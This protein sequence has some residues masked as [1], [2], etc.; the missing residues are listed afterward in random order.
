MY[1]TRIMPAAL[2]IEQ[3]AGFPRALDALA[4]ESLAAHRFLRS[5][6]FAA[7]APNGGA[8]L[9]LR[10][11]DASLLAAIPTTPFGPALIGA[12]KVPG[13]YWPHRGVLAARDATADD[14]AHVLS[15]PQ[16]RNLG[17][18]W[19]LGPVPE[20][21]PAAR[22]LI[23]GAR[24][25]GW[26]VL[27]HHAGTIWTI[28]L[29]A[30]RARGWPSKSTRRKL[31]RYEALANELGK[32]EWRYVRG[33]DWDESALEQMG[34]IEAASWVGTSTDGSGA[35]FMAPHQRALWRAALADPVLAEMLCATILLINGRAVAFTFDMDDG[36]VQYGIAGSYIS[37]LRDYHVGKLT[38]YRAISDAIADGQAVM[39]MGA[40][41]SG[42][43]TE[44]G[45]VPAYDLVDHLFVRSRLVAGMLGPWWARQGV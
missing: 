20:H 11:E 4:E 14:F 17:P 34:A 31:R 1:Q 33:S 35:K 42:Y 37:E 41:D 15:A 18:V 13:S 22:L 40:G 43:K 28:D 26:S 12:R 30:Q 36:P 25:A 27:T 5:A 7:A 10:R 8:T 44:M 45:A 21:D 24:Q 16:A 32:V 38:N 9:M 23:N 39:D 29:D 2:T 19:R 6:W 3:A